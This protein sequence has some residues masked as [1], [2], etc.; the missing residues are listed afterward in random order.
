MQKFDGTKE[1]LKGALTT[2]K[3]FRLNASPALFTE[4]FGDD[5]DMGEKLWQ[6]YIGRC[7]ENMLAFWGYLDEAHQEVLL[8][9]L[10]KK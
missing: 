8:N 5:K 6:S 3:S 9:F 7:G 4:V 1:A 2:L 10:L